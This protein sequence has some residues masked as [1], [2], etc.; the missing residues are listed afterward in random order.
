MM[1]RKSFLIAV[2]LFAAAAPAAF[3]DNDR[4]RGRGGHHNDR[5]R[6][7]DHDRDRYRNDRHRDRD[8]DRDWDRHRYRDN[9]RLRLS[10]SFGV[11]YNNYYGG[12]DY[13]D[14]GSR[15]YNSWYLRPHECRV[16]LEQDWWR[17]RRANIEV[18]RC[19][20]AYGNVYIVQGA[21]RLVRYW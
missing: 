6:D 7:R 10:F 17:G 21:R 8:W 15:Y 4:G 3:A 11:P 18:R 19:A 20:D 13:Y 14:Y 2:A 16:D 9:D 1:L 5:H 12:R